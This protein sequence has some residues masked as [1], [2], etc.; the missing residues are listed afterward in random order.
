MPD[1]LL[2]EERARKK[3]DMLLKKAGWSIVSRDKY[4]PGLSAVAIEEGILKGNL[5]AD[6]LLFLEG[7]AI[8]VLEAK[9]ELTVLSDVVANQAENYT[10]Q[11]LP[12]YQYWERPLPLIY[13][14]NGKELLFRN[15]KESDGK[16]QKLDSM[17]SPKRMA[18]LAGVKSY[19]IG[20]PSLEKKGLRDCQYEA[21]SN[22]EAS[23]RNGQQRA[24]IVL[25]TGAGK[26]FTAC[27]AAYRLLTYTPAR[28]VLFLV[29]RNN[30]GKQAAGEFGDFKLTETGEPFNTIYTTER[31]RSAKVPK[32]AN[33]VI[34]TIQ[35]LFAVITGQELQDGDD[36]E[37]AFEN[38][39]APAV[40]LKGKL[41]LPPD[42]FDLI[43]V[44]ECHRSI[45]G[46]WQKVLT[47]FCNARIIGLTATP[48]E[49]T[50]NFFNN[51]RVANY[52]LEKSIADGINVD[53]RIYSI[54]TSA[55]VNG[56]EIKKGE[57][58]VE[59]AVYTGKE[60]K[61]RASEPSP[62]LPT[63]LDRAVINPEQ[64]RLVLD[65][66]KSAIYRDMYPYR[67]PNF[68][69]IPKTLIFAKSDSHADN[70]IK[71]I[72][73]QV[74]P[75]QCLEF[76]QKITYSAGDSNALIKSFRNDKA[77]RIAVTV[78]LVATG[79][80]VKP[81]E[82]LLFMR[83]VNSESLYI[84]MRGRGCR[85]IT[86]DA[87]RNVTPNADTKDQFFL[88]DAIGVTKHKMTNHPP[89]TEGGDG[90]NIPLDKLLE[91]IAHGYLPDDNL[92]LLASRLSRIHDKATEIQRAEFEKFS[93]M[94]MREMALG[95]FDA[96]EKGTL[97]AE[98]FVS[99]NQPNTLRKALV[100]P[101]ALH[102]EARKYLLILNAGF[103][104]ILQPGQDILVGSGF[105]VEDAQ[106]TTAEFESYLQQH[107]DEEE[108]IRIIAE[109]TGEPI[110]YDMLADL[111]EKLKSVNHKF[112]AQTLWN[113]YS[114]INPDHVVPFKN[115]IEKEALTNL[116]QLI[117]FAFKTTAELRSLAS[118]AAQRFE[119]WCGQNQRDRLSD[120]QRYI[121]WEITN[122]IVCSGACSRADLS[123]SKGRQFLMEAKSAFG[124]MDNVDKILQSLSGFMLAA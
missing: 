63:D 27:L 30:L 29:D 116:I 77:F 94:N 95:I 91:Q 46:R 5:E 4:S 17:H 113:A 12:M 115:Q 74:F 21:V 39:N 28:R 13:L 71:I 19:F 97:M 103:V 120:T 108:A 117:R 41:K 23:F 44:D 123:A 99:S 47:Y 53:R 45:Y 70:I 100:A 22:L 34:C 76:A 93:G 57:K 102:A 10:H 43:I 92:R 110:T 1:G 67:E 54:E 48:G 80:D 88:V 82:I 112:Q 66:F 111:A 105:S 18:E 81:L 52:T 83:D 15:L 61:T 11:L 20:L 119:L 107:R 69:Y 9:K 24:L 8:G 114:V 68:A 2:P 32:Q 49:E 40:E 16:Y 79:T 106:Q 98:P 59:V 26:T 96:F 33:L 122:Y 75:G 50:L 7:K 78:T 55:T 124:S 36:D 90:V 87:L 37:S 85:K 72:R 121:V 62:Y 86:D 42:F 58:F 65:T 64:I 31:L 38:E 56:G 104:K 60:R 6:Y 3:I 51:N 73:E 118:L 35:R 25:A 109:N 89:E 84:Q 101:L 14:S